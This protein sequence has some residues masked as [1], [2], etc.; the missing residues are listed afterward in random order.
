MD[1]RIV[2]IARKQPTAANAP[3]SSASS[4]ASE[5]AMHLQKAAAYQISKYNALYA[6]KHFKKKVKVL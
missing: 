6:G 2:L 1:S 3:E 4:S 5:L